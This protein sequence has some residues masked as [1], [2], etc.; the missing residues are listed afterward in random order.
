MKLTPSLRDLAHPQGERLPIADTGHNDTFPIEVGGGVF[1]VR[2]D[3][4]VQVSALGGVVP[5]AQFLK[6]SGL[7]DEWVAEAPLVPGG[8]RAHAP[9]DVLGTMLLSSLNG[10]YRFAHV[11][12]LRGD[13]VVPAVLGMTTAVSEDAVRRA[14]KKM[15]E[16]DEARA[17]TV[18]WSQ[19]H[20]RKTLEPL[21]A[22]PWV[23]DVDVTIKP[24]F[25]YQPGS[26]VG[27]N[28]QKPGR[29][30]HALHS[31]VMARTRLVLEVVVHPGNEH[32]VKSTIPDFQSVLI[33]LPR[34]LWPQFARGD[35]AF[36]TEAMMVWPEANG[37]DYLFKQRM[38]TR[39]RALVQE[40]DLTQGWVDTRQG[41]EG[42]E[43]TLRLSTWTR[44]RRVI[45]LRRPAPKQRYLRAKDLAK[46]NAP[47]Q[48]VI[49]SCLPHLVEGDYEYQVLVTSLTLDI[50]A[51]AQLYR[52]RADVE[53][54]F[55]E[56]K[57]HWG[58]GG[59]T[60]HTFAVT[61]NVARMTA[62]FYN[63]WSIFCRLADPNHHR[64]AITTRP[65]LLHSIVRQTT[66]GG[67]RMLTITSTNGNKNA[68][69]AFFT[70]LGG[71]L[72]AFNTIAEQWLP[73][74]RWQE[75]LRAIFPGPFGVI[76]DPSG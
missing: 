44:A 59:F 32:T 64:E 74:R 55:D 37:L 35:S 6:A 63:W 14:M 46:A 42:K 34:Q 5:F 72:S 50:P 54:V 19:R 62:L 68:I 75:L 71:W 20:L 60:S 27:Y 70:R 17:Q 23:M 40:L 69:S 3:A 76:Y 67:Q 36:G 65:A 18:S 73:P 4:D 25:G 52:D 41:W 49:E 66:S 43:S 31:F 38:T 53:N 10:H 11:T 26:V 24:V 21:M 30:S 39:T 13:T 51:I 8:N 47:T 58:W 22:L 56:I 15:V 61:Q 48:E 1:H 33:A 9:Q 29:P 2:F 45:I 28:P 7:F 16:P 12:A 57:N